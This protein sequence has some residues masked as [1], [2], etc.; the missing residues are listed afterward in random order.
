MPK[1]SNGRIQSLNGKVVLKNDSTVVDDS[2]NQQD[3]GDST[4]V[5]VESDPV[6]IHIPSGEPGEKGDK[7]DVGPKGDKGDKGEKGDPGEDGRVG[8]VGPAGPAGRDGYNGSDGPQGVAGMTG[9]VGPQGPAGP[10]GPKGSDG[11]SGVAGERGLTG[12]DGP[13]GPQGPQ[14]IRGDKGDTGPQGPKGDTGP[15]GIQGPAGPAGSG[16]GESIDEPY[17]FYSSIFGYDTP[18]T[19]IDQSSIMLH[20]DQI[21]RKPKRYQFDLYNFTTDNFNFFIENGSEGD[22][23]DVIFV[24]SGDAINSMHYASNIIFPKDSDCQLSKKALTGSEPDPYDPYDPYASYSPY[25][26]DYQQT[27]FRDRIHGVYADG[28]WYMEMTHNFVPVSS[29]S[30]GGEPQGYTTIFSLPAILP[31]VDLSSTSGF[32]YRLEL[33]S[34]AHLQIDTQL[35]RQAG[36]SVVDTAI[37]LFNSSGDVINHNDDHTDDGGNNK[38]T[39]I[40]TTAGGEPLPAGVYWVYAGYYQF[41]HYNNWVI[42]DT[43]SPG[44]RSG[45]MVLRVSRLSSLNNV[46]VFQDTFSNMSIEDPIE[47][48]VHDINDTKWAVV[49][50]GGASGVITNGKYIVRN[51]SNYQNTSSVSLSS[52]VVLNSTDPYHVRSRFVIPDTPGLDCTLLIKTVGS[53]SGFSDVEVGFSYEY[54]A[55]TNTGRLIAFVRSDG[56][57]I[58]RLDKLLGGATGE[59][60]LTLDEDHDLVFD[61]SVGKFTWNLDGVELISSNQYGWVP[62]NNQVSAV[63]SHNISADPINTSIALREVRVVKGSWDG[64]LD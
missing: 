21:I 22:V 26:Y 58:N 3:V 62:S 7:G 52:D 54:A 10:A 27:E 41:D 44:N 16:G 19:S 14:G 17:R 28:L 6:M 46:T 43:S 48:H 59:P 2:D 25:S 11:A 32:W 33:S 18:Q 40:I 35:S 12:A 1:M 20:V 36:D 50:S 63:I 55:T 13:A 64:Y 51:N 39:S 4:T 15:Q 29:I 23:I 45:T 56:I 53:Y 24:H 8:D 34:D 47:D 38:S 42:L 61:V 31:D 5:P 30:L 49:S 9:P 57:T 60:V 37:V